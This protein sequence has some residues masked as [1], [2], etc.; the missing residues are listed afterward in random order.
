MRLGCA[1]T[2]LMLRCTPGFTRQ[3]RFR[4]SSVYCVRREINRR[5]LSA[6]LV[7]IHAA[8]VFQILKVSAEAIIVYARAVYTAKDNNDAL[9]SAWGVHHQRQ[10]SRAIERGNTI[11]HG[12]RQREAETL[13]KEQ[14]L[15]K[16]YPSVSR[17]FYGQYGHMFRWV[18]DAAWINSG[19]VYFN[20]HGCRS[21]LAGLQIDGM[22][23]RQPGELPSAVISSVPTEPVGYSFLPV[24]KAEL[25]MVDHLLPLGDF[26]VNH[27]QSA[28]VGITAVCAGLWILV[29]SHIWSKARDGFTTALPQSKQ[30]YMLLRRKFLELVP[31]ADQIHTTGL[32]SKISTPVLLLAGVSATQFA[33]PASLFACTAFVTWRLRTY[34]L[35][36]IMV[37][38][39]RRSYKWFPR[40]PL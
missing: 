6:A 16:Q 31:A 39:S 2:I 5:H 7:P 3:N 14:V 20:S 29:W 10:V 1:P 33:L 40:R 21:Q 26:C 35:R 19:I 18:L 17:M 4:I 22:A 27:P 9:R 30:L 15:E 12:L 25:L 34:L 36:E 24:S 28:A 32:P 13:S 11:L 23:A 37:A 38:D 8:I